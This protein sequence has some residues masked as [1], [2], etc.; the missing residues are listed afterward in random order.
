M[1]PEPE[2]VSSERHVQDWGP[3]ACHNDIGYMLYVW[4]MFA[5]TLPLYV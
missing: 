5:T 4:T 1:G 2:A 3:A